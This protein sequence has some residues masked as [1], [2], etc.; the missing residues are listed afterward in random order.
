MYYDGQNKPPFASPDMSYT[1]V[2]FKHELPADGQQ[3]RQAGSWG[4]GG[5]EM[6]AS[7]SPSTASPDHASMSNAS[8]VMLGQGQG[9]GQG[10]GSGFHVSPQSTGTTGYIGYGG[11]GERGPVSEMQG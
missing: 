10:G 2:H 9:Q 8:T 6:G 7:P 11:R 3:G 5:G 1:G 4:F